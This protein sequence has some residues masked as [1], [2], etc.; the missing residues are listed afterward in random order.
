M[1]WC[2]R[3]STIAGNVAGGVEGPGVVGQDNDVCGT[4][5]MR[6]RKAGEPARGVVAVGAD[7]V[8]EWLTPAVLRVI[9][10]RLPSL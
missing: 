4:L 6:V 7:G 10:A 3:S 9:V 2:R 1:S 5:R 8:A